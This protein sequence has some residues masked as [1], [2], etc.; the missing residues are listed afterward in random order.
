[1]HAHLAELAR[2]RDVDQAIE[3]HAFR[4]VGGLA[5]R[6]PLVGASR[7]RAPADE[8]RIA[9]VAENAAIARVEGEVAGVEPVRIFIL[10]STMT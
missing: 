10:S 8:A 5:E 2:E 6:E 7:D 3:L 1:M 9:H 4:L